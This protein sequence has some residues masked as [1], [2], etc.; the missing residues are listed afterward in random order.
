MIYVL[1]TLFTISFALYFKWQN[2]DEKDGWGG[3]NKPDKMWHAWGAVMRYSVDAIMIIACFL[4]A[5]WQDAVLATAIHPA[6]Y[7]MSINVLA[8]NKP[9]LYQGSS[10]WWDTKI[11]K[12]KWVAYAVVIAAAAFVKFLWKV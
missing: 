1:R 6:I 11:G 7:D 10:S 4:G 8:L 5:A 9:L 12:W 3:F 2:L